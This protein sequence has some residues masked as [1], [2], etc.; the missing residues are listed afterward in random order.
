[1]APFPAI[2]IK[3]SPVVQ[4]I[5]NYVK[6]V[7]F[8]WKASSFQSDIFGTWDVQR[9]DLFCPGIVWIQCGLPFS[10]K[11]H[12]PT[13]PSKFCTPSQMGH[14]SD[15]SGLEQISSEERPDD[16]N[17]KAKAVK[18]DQNAGFV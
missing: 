6:Q 1:M 8:C 4:I 12:V 3:T 17:L 11:S 2:V 10:S 18:S 15:A 9:E 5:Q 13:C 7:R 16:V 14:S